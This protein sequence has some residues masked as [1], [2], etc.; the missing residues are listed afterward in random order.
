MGD[1]HILRF[2]RLHHGRAFVVH[3]NET[4]RGCTHD[5][6]SFVYDGFKQ[7]ESKTIVI[8]IWL[9]GLVNS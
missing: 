4:D 7:V 5:H 9:D 8:L 6:F 1:G 2:V 3:H